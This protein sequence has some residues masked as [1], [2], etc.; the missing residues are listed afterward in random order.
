MVPD[1]EAPSEMLFY[2]P[3]LRA[4]CIA[5]DMTHNLHNLYTLRGAQ[6]RHAD[7]WWKAINQAMDRY[8]DKSD[9]MF[10]S[11]HWPTWGRDE[12]VGFMR[13]Q[14]DLYKFIN[15][16]SLRLLNLGYTPIEIAEMIELPESLAT[17]WYNRG[18]YG[19]MNHNTKAV[20]QRYLGWY[21]GN[22]ANLHTL[23]PT[24]SSTKYVEYMGGSAA[25]MNRAKASFKQGEYRWVAEVMNHVVFAEPQ[26]LAAKLL[27]ADA[28]EQLGYQAEAGPWRN[29]YLMGAFELRNGKGNVDQSVSADTI[30]AMSLDLYFEYLGIR[31]NAPKAERKKISINWNFTD[32]GQK[33]GT[34]L[35]NSG[36]MYR[37]RKLTKADA[38]L[39][40]TRATLDRITL[41]EISYQQAVEQGLVQV[42]GDAGKVDELLGML[43][44]FVANFDIV[45]P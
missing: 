12:I 17:E 20:Y 28:L 5:E 29:V 43:D 16:Q 25:I 23:P 45:T 26:N 42:G 33:Y 21:D 9:M 15:D 36:L 40:L 18:Y 39:T 6:V 13:K 32:T 31:L 44:E 34:M 8:G 7:S 1:T 2:F 22:P 24:E 30:R 3:Q 4:L 19:S 37:S 35:E 11:H 10:A 14:R 27:Q 38:M 41:H